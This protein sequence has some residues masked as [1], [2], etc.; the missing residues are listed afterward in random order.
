MKITKTVK[1]LLPFKNKAFLLTWEQWQQYMKQSNLK[2]TSESELKS[3]LRYLKGFP[4]E[5]AT[6]IIELSMQYGFKNFTTTI[7]LKFK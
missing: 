3:Q 2:Y 4:Q 6:K 5:D 7:M 1:S